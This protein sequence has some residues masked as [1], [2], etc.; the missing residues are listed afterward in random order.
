MVD[1]RPSDGGGRGAARQGHWDAGGA[2]EDIWWLGEGQGLRGVGMIK[3]CVLELQCTLCH[4]AD[5][6]LKNLSN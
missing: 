2:V 3:S 4:V 1:D 6:I 5:K